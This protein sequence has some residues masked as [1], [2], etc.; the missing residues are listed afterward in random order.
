[1]AVESGEEIRLCIGGVSPVSIKD[2]CGLSKGG[3][4]I[5][6]ESNLW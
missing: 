6:L 5:P 4:Q 3:S 1:M 2:E